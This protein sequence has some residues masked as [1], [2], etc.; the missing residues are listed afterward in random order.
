ML[1]DTNCSG[2]FGAALGQRRLL[3]CFD[4]FAISNTE[5]FSGSAN[6]E[7]D[8]RVGCLRSSGS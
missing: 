5:A 8:L 2:S 4:G 3:V 7:M 6:I 1:L